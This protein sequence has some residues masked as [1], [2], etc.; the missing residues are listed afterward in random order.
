MLTCANCAKVIPPNSRHRVPGTLT[1][2]P[3]HFCDHMCRVEWLD[4]ERK[5]ADLP[6][7]TKSELVPATLFQPNDACRGICECGWNTGVRDDIDALM[8]LARHRHLILQPTRR[9]QLL[10]TNQAES[11]GKEEG[12]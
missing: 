10:V 8:M 4:L 7:H 11:A 6:G 12:N 9:Q 3:I 1:G 5:S 2:M